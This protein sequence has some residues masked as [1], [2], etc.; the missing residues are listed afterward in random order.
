[1]PKLNRIYT[2]SGD[3][4][5]TLLSDGSRVWKDSQRVIAYGMVDEFNASIGVA[6]TMKLDDRLEVI[7][8]TIQNELFHLGADLSYPGTGQDEKMVVPRIQETHVKRLE[9]FIEEFVSI[10]GPLENFILPGGSSGSA[11]L[12]IARTICRRVEREVVILMKAEEV[13]PHVLPYLNRLSDLL[14][15]MARYE[16]KQRGVDEHLWDSHA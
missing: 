7:L 6:L 16:N 5:Q 2:R 15:V 13:N 9:Q 1:M 3:D 10:V 4:G 11:Y 8:R 12:H 14:F